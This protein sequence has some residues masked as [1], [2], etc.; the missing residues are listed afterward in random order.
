MTPHTELTTKAG[1]RYAKPG[2]GDE[3]LGVVACNDDDVVVCATRDGYAA[4][5]KAEEINKLENPGRGVTVIK[6]ADDDVV[7]GF[8]AGHKSD[9]LV[10]ETDKGGKTFELAAD[11]KAAKARGG[12]GHQIVKRATLVVVGK[13][14]AITPLANAEGGQGVN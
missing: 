4:F 11:P 12:K 2:E 13:P 1:R 6:T 14:V 9:K 7:I 10:V 5:C 8:I 3:V